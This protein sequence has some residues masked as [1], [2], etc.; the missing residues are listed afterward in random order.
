MG[1]SVAPV[2]STNSQSVRRALW[3]LGA[4]GVSGVGH[5]ALDVAD[6]GI[7]GWE[8]EFMLPDG[9]LATELRA[10]G[11]VTHTTAFGRRAGTAR[12]VRALARVGQGRRFAVVHSHLAW[13]DVVA[14]LA[15]IPGAIRITT[16]HGIADIPLLY[17]RTKFEASVMRQVHSFRLR[18]T[19]ATIA[20][21]HATA[22]AIERLWGYPAAHC[23]VVPNGMDHVTRPRPPDGAG[24]AFVGRLAPEKDLPTLLDAFGYA[25]EA[26]PG[27]TL[28][29]AGEGPLKDDLRKEIRRR[30]WEHR[31]RLRGWVPVRELLDNA[32]VL[33]QLSR[34]E[35]CSYS[36]LEALARGRGVVA[37]AVGGNPELLPGDSLVP[38][39]DA[40]A[41]GE[42]MV[43]Q[44][45]RPWPQ[46]A[47][48]AKWPT[49]KDMCERIADTYV[50][51]ARGGEPT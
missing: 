42:R 4:A 17:Q 38:P 39:G 21:S 6:A 28:D 12:S 5:H 44:A 36:L 20:V 34:W 14:A 11:A 35:N 29:V 22:R 30:G 27:A 3:V 50:Q 24:F 45:K 15:P 40:R 13:A 48:P 49:V 19:A 37:T 43:A 26:L 51:Q 46:S 47:L 23:V 31:V 7:P 2:S 41:A 25:A 9:V 18:R 33:V 1:E 32:A 8:I 10:A 16:E